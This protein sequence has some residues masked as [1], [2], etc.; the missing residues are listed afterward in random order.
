MN[1]KLL[2]ILLST[3]ANLFIQFGV[4]VF[5][6]V[7]MIWFHQEAQEL[8]AVIGVLSLIIAIAGANLVA[9]SIFKYIVSAS[10]K[11]ELGQKGNN[12]ATALLVTVVPIILFQNLDYLEQNLS[13]LLYYSAG[14]IAVL[15]GFVMVYF[16]Q[17]LKLEG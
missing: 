11:R 5:M 17:I 10:T 16:L 4:M 7:L 8:S 3:L 15:L 14:V 6:V 1:P 13:T 2:F 9:H 12:I